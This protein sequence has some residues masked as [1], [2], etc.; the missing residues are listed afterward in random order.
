MYHTYKFWIF[1]ILGKTGACA[2]RLDTMVRSSLRLTGCAWWR[3]LSGVRSFRWCRWTAKDPWQG[4]ISGSSPVPD[5]LLL[6]SERRLDWQ[7]LRDLSGRCPEVPT[8]TWRRS[9][10][11]FCRFLSIPAKFRPELQRERQRWNVCKIAKIEQ[12]E[13]RSLEKAPWS[14]RWLVGRGSDVPQNHKILPNLDRLLIGLSF[15]VSVQIYWKIVIVTSVTRWGDF[16]AF[17]ASIQQ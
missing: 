1:K 2:Q 10:G 12:E 3:R 14:K 15:T 5:N 6:R 13:E 11:N 17:W 8:R 9:S 4:L 7:L 16:F